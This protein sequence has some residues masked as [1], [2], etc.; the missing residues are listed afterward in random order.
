[1]MI[2]MCGESKYAEKGTN[3][4]RNY[5]IVRLAIVKNAKEVKTGGVIAGNG[6]TS[7][8]TRGPYIENRNKFIKE[9][10]ERK[11]GK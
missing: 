1:M 7:F 8:R 6:T 2:L 10:S 9:H 11:R 4:D 3:W 5:T